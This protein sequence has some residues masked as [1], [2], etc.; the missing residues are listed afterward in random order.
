M[1][2]NEMTL[3]YTFVI[4]YT[5]G[6]QISADTPMSLSMATHFAENMVK[7]N[8]STFEAI[9]ILD[10]YT[11]EIVYSVKANIRIDVDIEIYN[12]YNA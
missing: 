10:N 4:T 12:P 11:G 1:N 7:E 5:D 6:E 9:E 3:P 8:L 2:F